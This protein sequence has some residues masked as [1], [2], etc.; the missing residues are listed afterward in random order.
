MEN[1]LAFALNGFNLYLI[2]LNFYVICDHD[3]RML[4]KFKHFG[5]QRSRR[6]QLKMYRALNSLPKLLQNC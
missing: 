4:L 5:K 3:L 2:Y 6:L 1:V